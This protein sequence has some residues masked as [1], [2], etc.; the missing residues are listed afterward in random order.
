MCKCPD[1]Y[2]KKG[3]S[4]VRYESRIG[5]ACGTASGCSGGA[6]CTSSF[7]QCQDQYDADVDECYPYE[8]SV[9]SRNVKAIS[10]RR[11][12]NRVVSGKFAYLQIYLEMFEIVLQLLQLTVQ[13][14]M[15]WLMECV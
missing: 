3:D 2:F 6:T 11:K 8:P 10:G 9:R 14:D 1:D 5:A 13:L 15:I 4:C 12:V 7:C